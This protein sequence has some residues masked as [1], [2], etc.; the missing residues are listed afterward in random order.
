M[1]DIEPTL[2]EIIGISQP[3][4]VNGIPQDPMDGIS[5]AY[6]IDD[7]DAPGRRRTQYFE[8]MGS[9]SIYSDGWMAS[10]VGPRLP[11]VP[12][13]PPG[14]TTWTPDEDTWELY[15]LDH[16]WSQ[17]KDL[18]EEHP[19]KL[20]ELKELF[21]IEAA[22]NDAL[23]IGGGLWVPVMHPEDRISP[24]YTEWEMSGDTVRVPEFCAPAL[25]NRPNT[26]EM[27]VHLGERA[28]GV[29][30]KLGGA[31]GGLTCFLADGVLTYEYN[32]FLIQRTTIASGDP[33]PAGDVTIE[34]ETSYVEPRPGG[35]LNVVLRVDGTEV[36]SGTVPVSAPLLFS[37]NDCLDIGRAYGGAV[38]RQYADR[39]PFAFDGTIGRVHIAY[40][41]PD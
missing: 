4:M 29:L 38:S 34:I 27:E 23:P 24:P 7:A 33:I 25:G 9:R 40:A 28:T 19:E 2:Y 12:G 8:I 5:L 39:M 32:L 10:A 31:G 35:P 15:D 36:G 13:A 16:D 18:A 3:E 41:K 21:A 14:I 30:Y 11:W 20:A 22:R 1:I 37:A 26:V 17:A 6:S